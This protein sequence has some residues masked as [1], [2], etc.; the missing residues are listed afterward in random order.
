[1]KVSTLKNFVF[2]TCPKIKGDLVTIE[3]LSDGEKQLYGR[4][5]ALMMLEPHKSMIL[6]YES[7]IIA[8]TVYKNL[9]LLIRENNSII[10]VYPQ[11]PPSS[12]D[13]N[14]ILT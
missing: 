5:V 13:V 1:L 12:V 14:S 9:I 6:I 10:P 11:H 2:S 3:Q 4:V 7:Q 8:N